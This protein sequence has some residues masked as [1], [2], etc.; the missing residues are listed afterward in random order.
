MFR[1]NRGVSRRQ[2]LTGGAAA[3]G[4][5]ALAGVVGARAADMPGMDHGSTPMRLRA[6]TQDQAILVGA[7]ADRI[8]PRDGDSPAASELGVVTYLD[9]QLAGGWGAGERFYRQ[10][11]FHEPEDSGHGYQLSL[12]PR[13]IY[14]DVLP[15]IEAYV[16][17]KYGGKAYA[18]L[19]SADQDAV[20]TDLQGGKVD[21][22]L[23]SGP[24]GY[25]SASFFSMFMQ[26]VLEGLFGDPTYG[27]NKD[28]AGW[29]WIDYPGDPMAYGD[30]YYA[31]FGHRGDNYEVEPKGMADAME[32]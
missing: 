15:K 7:M 18:D 22:G 8:W 27:G 23:A 2:L 1:T 10:G 9:G 13:D 17:G 25:T 5:V 30:S 28:L 12:T 24:N 16:K 6:L 11:P 32:N 20:L 14:R 4:S 21:L 26:N 29:K 31:I 3:A 19:D